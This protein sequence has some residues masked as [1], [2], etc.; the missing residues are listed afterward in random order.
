MRKAARPCVMWLFSPPCSTQERPLFGGP[1]LLQHLQG[2]LGGRGPHPDS[3]MDLGA[4][5]GALVSRHP[6]GVCACA[7]T[8]VSCGASDSPYQPASLLVHRDAAFA[9]GNGGRRRR[10]GRASP[11]T[12]RGPSSPRAPNFPRR[13]RAHLERHPARRSSAGSGGARYRPLR[14]SV[15]RRARGRDRAPSGRVR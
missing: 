10:S 9:A 15:P 4:F 11:L 5:V 6:C 12:G 14:G 7:S 2:L 13:P 3:G 1:F 8:R